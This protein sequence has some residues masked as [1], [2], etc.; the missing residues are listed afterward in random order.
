MK[1]FKFEWTVWIPL[2][3]L[4]AMSHFTVYGRYRTIYFA[5]KIWELYQLVWAILIPMIWAILEKL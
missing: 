3:G 1:K 2:L 5:G 4:I